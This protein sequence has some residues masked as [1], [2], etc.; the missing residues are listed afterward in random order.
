MAPS[1]RQANTRAIASPILA[2]MRATNRP[3]ARS[4]TRNQSLHIFHWIVRVV[5]MRFE[6]T[7]AM[8]LIR[9]RVHDRVLALESTRYPLFLT[10]CR[11]LGRI[12]ATP[13]R[14]AHV[15]LAPVLLVQTWSTEFPTYHSHTYRPTA[16]VSTRTISSHD[17]HRPR[18]IP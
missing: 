7:Q 14:T 17:C 18:I 13:R 9:R 6:R 5:R 1:A 3:C 10:P 16:Y 4:R 12:C 11:R 8:R 15:H 2:C